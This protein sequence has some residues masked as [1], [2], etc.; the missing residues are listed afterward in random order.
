MS[1]SCGCDVN[2]TERRYLSRY[3][4]YNDTENHQTGIN[5]RSDYYSFEQV[6]PYID[7]I[8]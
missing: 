7:Q 3:K 8:R 2:A 4:Y 1:N 5:D 6:D